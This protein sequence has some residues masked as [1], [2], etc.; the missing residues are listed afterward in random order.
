MQNNLRANFE[1]GAQVII[2]IAVL[3]VAGVLIKRQISPQRLSPYDRPRINAGERLNL[4]DV[5]WKQSKKRLVFFLNKDCHYC[6]ASAP[7]YKQLTEEGLKHGVRSL[8]VL[9]NSMEEAKAYIQSVKLPIDDVRIGPLSSYKIP[10][11][12]TV[13]LVNGSGTV[14]RVWSGAAPGSEKQMLDEFLA[15]I[16][17][18][19]STESAKP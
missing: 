3:V 6:T 5:D 8:A 15:S 10:G 14:E 9:P 18:P 19:S 11:T 2:A 4:P 12:P 17:N 1:L 13:L 7:F 16:E